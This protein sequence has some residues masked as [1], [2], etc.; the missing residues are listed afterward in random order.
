MYLQ[1]GKLFYLI[2]WR[3]NEKNLL[4]NHKVVL[5][6]KTLTCTFRG[7]V[8]YYGLKF[9]IL[10][11][12]VKYI[13]L[14]LICSR[15]KADCVKQLHCNRYGKQKLLSQNCRTGIIAPFYLSLLLV[16]EAQT[17]NG[18]SFWCCFYLKKTFKTLI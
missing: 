10:F 17:L 12:H 2:R 3:I 14:S 13:P 9:L 7:R 5:F 8:A 18:T 15:M 1:K 6:E 4:L 11:D 16:T